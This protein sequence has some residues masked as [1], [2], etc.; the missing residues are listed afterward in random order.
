MSFATEQLPYLE[1]LAGLRLAGAEREQLAGH[2]A[3]ILAYVVQLNELDTAGIEPC[4]Y[5]VATP[6][7][8]RDDAPGV[9]LTAEEV[10][11][12]APTSQDGFFVVPPIFGRGTEETGDA[13]AEA[14]DA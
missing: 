1:R 5:A 10:L 9:P 12:S 7:P 13:V 4:D 14:D 8:R 11:A 3:R 6:C 2:L